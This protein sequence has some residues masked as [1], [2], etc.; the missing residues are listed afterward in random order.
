L[1]ENTSQKSLWVLAIII[2]AIGL[3][4]IAVP[5]YEWSDHTINDRLPDI[6]GAVVFVIGLIFFAVWAYRRL[7]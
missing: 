4:I 2:C 5:F 6:G 3:A 1:A 7:K